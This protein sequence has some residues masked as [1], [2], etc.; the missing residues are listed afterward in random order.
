MIGLE[1]Y[2]CLATIM[3]VIGL[4]G[5]A[6]NRNNMVSLLMSIELILLACNTNF[7]TFSKMHHELTGDVFVFFVLAIAA[8]ETAI[9]L[10]ILV[11]IF[12]QLKTI[13]SDKLSELK[14]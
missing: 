10:A 7:V 6:I 12:R 4:I 2:V 13:D 3:F 9:G 5:I 8:I 1:H 11:V 14:G